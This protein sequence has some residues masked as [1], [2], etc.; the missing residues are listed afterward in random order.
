MFIK[1]KNAH[2]EDLINL[3][4]LILYKR[5]LKISRCFQKYC[6]TIFK[7]RNAR[8]IGREHMHK[9]YSFR[10]PCKK[11]KSSRVI[12]RGMKTADKC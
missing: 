10:K 7:Q 1:S 5:G 12:V 9:S 3:D 8:M 11:K 4:I 2:L 6:K